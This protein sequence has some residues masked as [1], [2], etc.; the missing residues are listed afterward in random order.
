VFKKI[1]GHRQ[2]IN[3]SLLTAELIIRRMIPVFVASKR[4]TITLGQITQTK[5]KIYLTTVI[6]EIIYAMKVILV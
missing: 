3:F 5:Q 1:F 2:T 6:M 4:D